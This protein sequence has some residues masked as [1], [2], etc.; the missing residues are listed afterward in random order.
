MVFCESL[1][2][3]ITIIIITL[4]LS[5]GTMYIFSTALQELLNT[6]TASCYMIQSMDKIGN[7][8]HV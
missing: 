7:L 1:I 8:I 2:T 5:A 6:S 4:L 3:I